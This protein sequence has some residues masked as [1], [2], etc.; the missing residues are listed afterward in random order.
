MILKILVF[1][2]V[3]FYLLHHQCKEIQYNIKNGKMIQENF[4]V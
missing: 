1:E 2:N 4:W 3:L